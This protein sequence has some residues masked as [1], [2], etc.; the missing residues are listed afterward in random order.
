MTNEN[1]RTVDSTDI[2]QFKQAVDN[3]NYAHIVLN[4]GYILTTDW[5][6]DGYFLP[7]VIPPGGSLQD[8]TDK[9]IEERKDE[10][11]ECISDIFNTLVDTIEYDNSRKLDR[12]YP[13]MDKP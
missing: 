8:T 6:G 3:D 12:F 2:H 5:E 13:E 7:Y 11:A 1:K 10:I 4:N 9:Y